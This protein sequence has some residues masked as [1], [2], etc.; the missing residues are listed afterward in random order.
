MT[1]WWHDFK[2]FQVEVEDKYQKHFWDRQTSFRE[3]RY[4]KLSLDCLHTARYRWWATRDLELDLH[5]IWTLPVGWLDT[6]MLIIYCHQADRNSQFGSWK[7]IRPVRG[8][9][10]EISPQKIMALY[11][12]LFSTWQWAYWV[13]LRR[14]KARTGSVGWLFWNPMVH[15]FFGEEGS[16]SPTRCFWSTEHIAVQEEGEKPHSYSEKLS[17]PERLSPLH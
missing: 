12:D 6:R 2:N 16:T 10:L 1:P 14:G 9:I 17:E 7:S 13:P 5:Q 8:S 3:A 11:Q 4:D 15:S